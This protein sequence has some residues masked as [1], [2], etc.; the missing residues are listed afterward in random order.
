VSKFIT[1][2]RLFFSWFFVKSTIVKYFVLFRCHLAFSVSYAFNPQAKGSKFGFS[3]HFKE[4]QS[5]LASGDAVIL[6][7]SIS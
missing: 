4:S 7:L 6:I 1:K 3:F 5:F 2:K